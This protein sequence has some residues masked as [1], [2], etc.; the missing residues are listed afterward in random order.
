[1]IITSGS[2]PFASAW[3]RD[4]KSSLARKQV[5]LFVFFPFPWLAA[6]TFSQH[7]QL[8]LHRSVLLCFPLVVALSYLLPVLL[9]TCSRSTWPHAMPNER[10][11]EG[12]ATQPSFCSLSE[13]A[14]RNSRVSQVVPAGLGGLACAVQRLSGRLC[15]R[16]MGWESEPEDYRADFPGGH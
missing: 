1:M 16:W 10:S 3:R 12:L 4:C 8:S 7:S 11:A 5:F 9:L 13:V 2:A 14:G 15:H 6:R